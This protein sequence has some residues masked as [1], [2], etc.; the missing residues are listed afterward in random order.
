MWTITE[1]SLSVALVVDMAVDDKL[2]RQR[3][4]DLL[5]LLLLLCVVAIFECSTE[6]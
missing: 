2:S 6:K 1:W 4:L 5:L 3:F